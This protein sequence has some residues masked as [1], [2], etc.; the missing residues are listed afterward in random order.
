M[1]KNIMRIRDKLFSLEDSGKATEKRW[2]LIWDLESK[3]KAKKKTQE[4]QF[5]M[6]IQE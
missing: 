3:E 1:W 4:R 2:H 5:Q 6:I